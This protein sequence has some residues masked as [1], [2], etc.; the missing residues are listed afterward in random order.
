MRF[1]K[2]FFSYIL[3]IAILLVGGGLIW[4]ESWLILAENQVLTDVRFLQRTNSWSGVASNCLDQT[5][6]PA[7]N[8]QLRFLNNHEYVL[9]V[10]CEDARYFAW[11]DVKKLPWRVS[12]TS[13]SA[14]FVV[15]IDG[16]TVNGEVTLSFMGQYKLLQGKAQ[17]VEVSWEQSSLLSDSLISSCQA[18]GLTCCD[19]ATE[20]GLGEAFSRGVNDCQAACYAV[21]V[22]RPNILFFQSDPPADAITR[23]VKLNRNNTFILFNYT[24]EQ[25]DQPLKRVTIDFGDGTSESFDTH[26]GKAT[27]EFACDQPEC[28]YTVQISAMDE[29]GVSS[30]NQRISKLEIVIQ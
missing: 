29:G 12:K 9:E 15:P 20:V 19:L 30:A 5:G 10:A 3:I 1:L 2:H 16:R 8:I 4:R 22:R 27:K 14:G 24:V 26:R 25:T 17:E 6:T 7:V 18:H 11:S 23:Q 28:R 13:G 21:C